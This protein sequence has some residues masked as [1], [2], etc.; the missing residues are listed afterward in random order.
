MIS[1]LYNDHQTNDLIGAVESKRLL[2]DR[3]DGKYRAL[4]TDWDQDEID[5][6]KTATFTT[7]STITSTTTTITH[8]LNE[9]STTLISHNKIVQQTILCLYRL[10]Y[11]PLPPSLVLLILSKITS[12]VGN[13]W[14]VPGVTVWTVT[15]SHLL[16]CPTHPLLETAQTLPTQDVKIDL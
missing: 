9:Q 1:R 6:W 14:L 7:T 2:A 12:N 11:P 13:G 8:L 15:L 10:H 4:A 5:L 3:L 16:W